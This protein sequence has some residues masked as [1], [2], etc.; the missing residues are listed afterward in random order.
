MIFY[1]Y[2]ENEIHGRGIEIDLHEYVMLRETP[3]GY[4]IIS[5]HY[6]NYPKS[7]NSY[8]EKLKKWISKTSR[9]KYAYLT[10]KQALENFI[11]RKRRQIDHSLYFLNRAKIA[12]FKAERILEELEK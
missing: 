8:L 7:V 3:Q 1:R 12:K 5:K 10:K 2:H 9:K 6:A 11:A 4:W